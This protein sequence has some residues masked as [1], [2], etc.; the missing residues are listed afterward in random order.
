MKLSKIEQQKIKNWLYG[1][2][3][4]LDIA[5]LNY[6]F[7]DGERVNILHCISIYQNKDGGF[8]NGLDN[9]SMNP[10]STYTST[11]IALQHIV[12]AGYTKESKDEVFD[13]ILK[14]IL[15]YLS[16]NKEFY[17]PLTDKKNNK[18]PG[19]E[20]LK[21]GS[22]ESKYYPTCY[23]LGSLYVLLDEKNPYFIV[24]KTKINKILAEYLN[25]SLNKEELQSMSYL[26][27]I[28]KNDYDVLKQ[29]EKFK[30]E[31]NRFEGYD[32]V[33]V[34][35]NLVETNEED[36]NELI[37]NRLNVGLWDFRYNWGNRDPEQEVSELKEISKLAIDNLLILKSY[38]CL[39]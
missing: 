13:Y 30:D 16:N 17:Y 9:A 34:N 20:Y 29:L 27:K 28:I 37:N 10:Y 22:K 6:H 1:S 26:L 3:R 19:A 8:G 31:I 24:T 2:G 11:A 4:D 23:I 25:D 32:K 35:N 14:R 5:R 7:E 38:D 12:E 18:F 39:E 21:N 33:I 15:K 36:I